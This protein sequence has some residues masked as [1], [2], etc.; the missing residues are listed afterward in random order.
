MEN[1]RLVLHPFSPDD[2]DFILAVL[3]AAHEPVGM[4]GLLQRPLAE[5][6]R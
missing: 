5:D 3:K 1:E 4:C 6:L 2:A